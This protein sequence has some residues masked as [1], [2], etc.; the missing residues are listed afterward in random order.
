MTAAD[1]I[2]QSH[3]EPGAYVVNG[4][5]N[6]MP[7]IWKPPIALKVNEIL[8]VDL[9]LQAQV[10]SVCAILFLGAVSFLF[11]LAGAS[12]KKEEKPVAIP[13]A[14]PQPVQRQT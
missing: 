6:E 7:V 5:K 1:Y 8:A 9:F 14:T 13:G 3:F 2:V 12:E 10:V 4:F 11:W